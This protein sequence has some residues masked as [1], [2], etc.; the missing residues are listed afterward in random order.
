MASFRSFSEIVSTMIQRLSLTQPNLDTKP[1]T[2]SRDVFVDLPA[3][4]ISRLYNALS[5]VSEKQSL[6]TTSGSDLEKLAANYGLSKSPGS[7][8]SGIVVF[9]ANSLV[10]D[11]SIPSGTIVTARNGI[12]FRTIGN[13]LM[14]SS[15]KNRLSANSSR[16]RK[17]LN[18]A[19]INTLY[20]LEI[21]VQ[22]VRVGTAGNVGS[23]QIVTTELRFPVVVTNLTS[24]TG[25]TNRESDDSF[26]AKILSV[27][28]GAN[29][30]TSSGYRNSILG[31][32]G[33]VDAMVVEPGNSLM[34]RDG[35]ETLALDDGSTRI[36][37]SGTGGKV[38]IY[39]LGRSIEQLSESFIFTDLSGSGNITDER[40]DF[41]LGQSN[42]DLTR[43][44]E[45]RRLISFSTGTLP[46]Q[47]VDSL[48]S[49]AGSLSGILS[50]AYS[51]SNGVTRGSYELVKD[52]NP[53]SGGSPF[54]FDK[55]HF[56]SSNKEVMGE[57]I[58]K[59]SNYSV[60]A[61]PFTDISNLDLVYIDINEVAENSKV[62]ISGNRYIQLL[63]KPVVKVSKIQ[64]KTTGETYSVVSQTLN[65]DGLN[66]TGIVQISGKTYPTVA[67]ILSCNYTWRH[68]FDR[69]IDYAT[70]G[71]GQFKDNLSSDSVDWT[72]TG[73]V[74]S[75]TAF[76]TKSND[77]LLYQVQ[78]SSVVNKINSIY[79]KKTTTVTASIVQNADAQPTLGAVIPL[80]E[81]SI[82]DMISIKRNSDG[83]ELYNTKAGDGSFQSRTI[84]FPSDSP[85]ILGD[86]VIVSYNKTELYDVD[87]GDGSFY[88]SIA[89]LPSDTVLDL[90]N[91]LSAVE[92][93][94]L[95]GDEV[96][97][98]YVA[99]AAG[100]VPST[101]FSSLPITGNDTNNSLFSN[102]SF[103][104]FST[105]QPT[106]FSYSLGSI[107]SI[108][109][110]GPTK[111]KVDVS[112]IST[113]GKIKIAGT[114]LNRYVL[115]LTS[116]ISR[117]GNTFNL[118]TELKKALGVNSIPS[119]VGIG[120]IDK[121]VTIT[122]S[123]A[124]NEEFDVIGYSIANP[125]YHLG[126][127]QSNP[128][129]NNF[130]FTL[131]STPVNNSIV[132]S[133]GD[134]I[135]VTILVYNTS[136][137]EEL[138]FN[139]S[140]SRIT[141]N[142]FARINNISVSSGFRSSSGNLVG[143]L[144]AS[145]ACQPNSGST[146]L[147]DYKFSSPKEG[148]RITVTYNINRVIIDATT[149]IESVRPVTADVLVKEASEILVDVSGTILINDDALADT[150]K[151]IEN[152]INAVSVLLNTSKLG[153][154]V[155]YS[156]IISV[157]AAESGVD[158]VNISLFN[159]SGMFGRKAYIKA[160]DNQTIS[161]GSILFDAVSR[162]KFRIN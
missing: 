108:N 109:R 70:D 57:T 117:S 88:N 15:D 27:F 71:I 80:T 6:A 150:N 114:T 162:N 9:C 132:T 21:P 98:K 55:L 17:G 107:R 53:E 2:V 26:R 105:N 81:D 141:E 51:D 96:Y 122:S 140:G 4:Q 160:L 74:E 44:I 113:S 139:L 127:A 43:T 155:D 137:F 104:A 115:N 73:G 149:T 24:M 148:E 3:D 116:G 144:I 63:H 49:V 79:L 46:A 95:G 147:V 34:L 25:A 38:D 29:V 133:S 126:W 91:I 128:S 69:Y 145:A 61:L 92:S 83:L 16:M 20:A 64:N 66:E 48:V 13:Y 35:T 151:I 52:L 86:S 159:E 131:P 37:N 23:L 112:G 39:V 102:V 130:T 42:Q 5:A 45:E 146:Y 72:S 7:A 75:E 8:A 123:G 1:G 76:L 85:A 40:N 60:D 154:T 120:R 110:F 12:Q 30:G 119:T 33:V 135:R 94:Y 111:I 54:G 138:Y 156:D 87:G 99:A 97:V 14:S 100:I 18:I 153:S 67:D 152:V 19:G 90:N 118:E 143:S 161:P 65:A 89:V 36:L 77:N 31:A 10:S 103:P 28:T 50:K 134:V 84:Y 11:I 58:I 82:N 62:S 129:L 22:A 125:T 136:A 124:E 121:V 142:R 32:D 47:P 59:P 158:S 68:S 106:N 56:I 41:V 78:L 101:A 157:A 93:A